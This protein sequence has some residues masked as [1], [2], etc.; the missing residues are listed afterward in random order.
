MKTGQAFSINYSGSWNLPYWVQDV[1][2]IKGNLSGSGNSEIWVSFKV[3]GVVE[4]TL[5]ANATRLGEPSQ[6]NLTLRILG[7]T[8]ITTTSNPT[9]EICATMAV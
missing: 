2:S 8:N 3:A 9:V 5:C 6:G 4:D 1:N 7:T